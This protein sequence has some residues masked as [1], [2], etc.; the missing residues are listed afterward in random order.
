MTGD[1]IASQQAMRAS[2]AID[3]YQATASSC[4]MSSKG[5]DAGCCNAMP[6]A[7]LSFPI[8][9]LCWHHSQQAVYCSSQPTKHK[10]ISNAAQRVAIR[11]GLTH[12]CDHRVLTRS[13]ACQHAVASDAQ[14]IASLVS[15]GL[16]LFEQ[17]DGL[18]RWSFLAANPRA[19]L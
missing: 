7:M 2:E 14:T 6:V 19:P 17:A 4:S 8:G 1:S 16:I 11:K 5:N 9:L 10:L 13:C 15:V 3:A 12:G 18:Y